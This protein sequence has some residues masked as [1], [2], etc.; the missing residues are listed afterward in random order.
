M[1]TFRY[2]ARNSS[3]GEVTGVLQG[4]TRNEVLLWLR[5]RAFTPV[6][7]E[8]VQLLAGTKRGSRRLRVRSSDMA[9]FCWQLN[10]MIEGG[11]TITDAIDTIVED[12]DNRRL[13]TVLKEVARK[14]REGVSFYDSVSE[15]PK[16]FN[17]L[18]CAMVRAGETSGMLTNILARLAEY[19]DRKDE[20]QRKV[21]KA[22][23]YPSFVV[24]FVF[25]VLVVM[26][27]LIIPRFLTIFDSFG[28]KLPAFTRGF[29][30]VYTFIV[31]NVHFMVGG[32]AL[33]V[34]LVI[35]YDSTASGHRQLSKLWLKLPLFGNIF[36]F[37]FVATYGRTMGTLLASGVPVLNALAIVEGMTRNDVIKDVLVRAKD[38]VAEG[39][40]IALSMAGNKIFPHLMVKMVQVGEESGSLPAVFDRSSNYYEKK[41]DTTVMTMIAVLEPMMIVLV[42]GIVLTVLLALYM[43]IFSMSE[44]VG[45][46]ER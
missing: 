7:L 44:S 24:G 39:V 27:T 18:F 25:L 38:Q 16:I 30:G 8:E 37:A 5:E 19:F 12:V 9:S 46:G 26:M 2:I 45:V 29:M 10:T 40:S 21:K 23:A 36:R 3:G 20:L 43:P 42:G 4:D 35:A 15:Y 17:P 33:F 14:M 31:H 11:V 1:S 6:S 41:V 22:M 28:A 34:I 13:Q 32:A